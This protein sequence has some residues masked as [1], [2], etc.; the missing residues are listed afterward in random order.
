MNIIGIDPGKEGGIV[1]L[2]DD[3]SVVLP[4][5]LKNSTEYDIS[6]LIVELKLL[7]DCYCFIEKVGPARKQGVASMF[8]FGQGYGFLRG[9]LVAHKIPFEEVPPTVWQAY[10]KC[11]PRGTFSRAEHKQHLKQRSQQLFPS[12]N[13]TL[14]T[15]DALLIAEYGR[16]VVLSSR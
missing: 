14:A 1:L 15:A 11:R 10:L 4:Y 13:I 3:T 9:L 16:R 7:G 12:I 5:S 6:T 2:S 8:T